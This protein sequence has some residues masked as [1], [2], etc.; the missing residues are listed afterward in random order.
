MSLLER[1]RV[2]P[3]YCV[4][5]FCSCHVGGAHS[6]RRGTWGS[7][8]RAILRDTVKVRN[9]ASVAATS[10]TGVIT[11]PWLGG[12]KD[13][14]RACCDAEGVISKR[15]SGVGTWGVSV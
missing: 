7:P 1:A 6:T 8:A 3:V 9:R 5:F 12:A 10:A 4:V 2:Q 14:S 11:H 15:W 13:W